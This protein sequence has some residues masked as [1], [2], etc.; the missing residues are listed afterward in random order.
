MLRSA[1]FEVFQLQKCHEKFMPGTAAR[2]LAARTNTDSTQDVQLWGWDPKDRTYKMQ[3]FVKVMF[4]DNAP[5][6]LNK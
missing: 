5:I 4:K 1:S 3:H 6:K 2:C